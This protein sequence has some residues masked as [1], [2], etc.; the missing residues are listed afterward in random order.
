MLHQPFASNQSHHRGDKTSQQGTR[1][2]NGSCCCC[3]C[4]RCCCACVR[5]CM[6]W[7][8]YALALLLLLP[9]QTQLL[10]LLREAG[11]TVRHGCFG[12]LFSTTN[13]FQAWFRFR[14]NGASKQRRAS[15]DAC[16]TTKSQRQIIVVDVSHNTLASNGRFAT[17]TA[18]SC[19]RPIFPTENNTTQKHKNNNNHNNYRSIRTLR[20]GLS[21]VQSASS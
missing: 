17:Q 5:A 9:H 16:G 1:Q 6:R 13:G 15:E 7:W 20:K 3:R 2:G 12:C 18:P 14:Q 19:A 11:S 10:A 21:S 8:M 4:R